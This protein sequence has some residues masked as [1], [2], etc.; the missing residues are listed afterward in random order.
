MDILSQHNSNNFTKILNKVK[1][2]FSKPQNVILFIFG[3]LLTFTTISPIIA[4]IADTFKIHPGTIDSHLTG[5]IDGYT[6]VNYI[7]LFTGDLVKNNL[8]TYFP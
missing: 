1:T 3:I 2:F 4:I 8:I 5:K 7:D 6:L